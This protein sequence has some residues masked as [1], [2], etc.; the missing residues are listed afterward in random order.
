M[1]RAHGFDGLPGGRRRLHARRQFALVGRMVDGFGL[2]MAVARAR[3]TH[4]RDP[5]SWTVPA[6]LGHAQPIL[7]V[8]HDQDLV[9][10]AAAERAIGTEL[11]PVYR[12][13]G[14][15]LAAP[16]GAP[17]QAHNYV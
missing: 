13:R 16:S 11:S 3:P 17:K 10:H 5:V 14:A 8:L 7:Y 15:D 2:P 4:S 9:K 12:A 1:A 6:L